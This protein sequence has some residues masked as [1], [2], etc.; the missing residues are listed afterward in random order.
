MTY[1][2]PGPVMEYGMPRLESELTIAPLIIW[3]APNLKAKLIEA[4]IRH[5]VHKL[6]NPNLVATVIAVAFDM[7]SN[8]RNDDQF[9]GERSIDGPRNEHRRNPTKHELYLL[10]L[11]HLTSPH[12]SDL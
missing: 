3:K 8:P 1:Y 4:L 5:L 11:Y 6:G 12:I 9:D 2:L 10:Y 7:T